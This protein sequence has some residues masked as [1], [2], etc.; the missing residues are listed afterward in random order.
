MSERP[1]TGELSEIVHGPYKEPSEENSLAT[2]LW[3]DAWTMQQA[4]EAHGD[5]RA[6][7]EA[8]QRIMDLQDTYPQ[9]KEQF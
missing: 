2:Q 8:M 4:A 1:G 7:D 9:L 6:Q 3:R 5:E